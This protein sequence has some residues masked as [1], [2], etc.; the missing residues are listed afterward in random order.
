M[1][2]QAQFSLCFWFIFSTIFPCHWWIHFG[3]SVSLLT[4]SNRSGL[5][6]IKWML[7]V[8]L[9]H[10]HSTSQFIQN[11]IFKDPWPQV[12]KAF[13]KVLH[14]RFQ[15]EPFFHSSLVILRYVI[16]TS[17]YSCARPF[18]FESSILGQ[19]KAKNI[20]NDI[21]IEKSDFLH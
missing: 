15:S 14:P 13:S 19:K 3:R 12:L 7:F 11:E 16:S 21:G 1:N 17:F 10:N 4:V 5:T 20:C 6:N 18:S 9:L 2:K 8:L